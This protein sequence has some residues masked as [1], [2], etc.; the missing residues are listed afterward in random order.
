MTLRR[1][2]ERFREP[3]YCALKGVAIISFFKPSGASRYQSRYQAA[4][5]RPSA[6]QKFAI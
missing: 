1:D 6:R 2:R 4:A 3:L 5:R